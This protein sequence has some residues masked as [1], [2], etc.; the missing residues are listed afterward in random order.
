MS[1]CI[2]ITCVKYLRC[3][4]EPEGSGLLSAVLGRMQENLQYD[5][6]VVPQEIEELCGDASLTPEIRLQALELLQ[7][8][9]RWFLFLNSC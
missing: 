8:Q 3:G 4:S 9:R 1:S 7:V 6:S 5:T 2:S